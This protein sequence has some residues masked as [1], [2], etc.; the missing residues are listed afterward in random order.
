MQTAVEL[1]VQLGFGGEWLAEAAASRLTAKTHITRR[2]L[3]ARD[4]CRVGTPKQFRHLRFC[5]EVKLT[6]SS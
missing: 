6:E 5:A 4:C 2:L 3:I 1:F